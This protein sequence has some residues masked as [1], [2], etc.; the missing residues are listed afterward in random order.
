M[1]GS[2]LRSSTVTGPASALAAAFLVLFG[3]RPVIAQTIAIVGGTIYP[4]SAPKIE[5]GTVLLRDGRI[6]AVGG[7]RAD[8]GRHTTD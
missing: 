3:A 7:G 8:P 1:P 6:V 5:R 2:P 4:V